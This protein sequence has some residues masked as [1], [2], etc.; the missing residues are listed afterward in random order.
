MKHWDEVLPGKVL[1]VNYEEVVADLEPQVRRVAAHCRLDWE[2]S[3]LRFHE[4]KRAVRT[5][6]SEQVRQPIYSGS[7]NL[8]RQYEEDLAELIDF[9]EPVLL[10]LP[11]EQRPQSMTG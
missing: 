8:W 10:E 1:R 7:V 4:T 9:L 6:R 5:A 2:D 3:M 11:E